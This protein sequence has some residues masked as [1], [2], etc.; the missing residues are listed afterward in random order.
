MTAFDIR[1]P[2]PTGTI[3][4]QASAGTGK[5]AAIAG[6]FAR[7]VAEGVASLPQ[8]MAATFSGAS[9]RELR[10]RIRDQLVS[11]ASA[12]S[13]RAAGGPDA[14]EV[15]DPVADLVSLVSEPELS[16]RLA[17]VEAALSGF[18]AATICTTHQFCDRMLAELGV[19]VDH[20]RSTVLVDDLTSMLEQ[21]VADEYLARFADSGDPPF[22]LRTARS[23]GK[24]AAVLSPALPLAPLDA[25]GVARERVAFAESVRRSV[26]ARKRLMGI[27][28]FDDM[29][30]RLRDALADD[31]DGLARAILRRRFPVV[32]IDEFQDTDPVQ[33]EIVDRAF[34][35]S[36][37]VVLIGDPKQ[38]IYGFRGADV[39]A[40]LAAVSRSQVQV[41]D[42]N[43]RSDPRL[44]RALGTLFAGA[45]LGDPRISVE[46][47][48]TGDGT[49]RLITDG[50]WRAPLRLRQGGPTPVSQKQADSAVDADLVTDVVALLRAKPN[51]ERPR[52]GACRPLAAADVAVI[53]SSNSRGEE[54]RRRLAE[55]GVP[56]V[57]NGSTSVLTS[58][59]ADDWRTLLAAFARPRS[60]EARRVARTDFIGWSLNDLATADDESLGRLVQLIRGWQRIAV[61]SGIGA[62]FEIMTAAGDIADRLLSR[63]GGDRVMTDLRHVAELLQAQQSREG[64]GMAQLHDWLDDQIRRRL[65]SR[66]ERSRR[67]ETD[68]DAVRIMTVHQSKGLQF[69]VVYFP[70]TTIPQPRG[71]RAHLEPFQVHQPVA[72]RLERFLDVGGERAPGAAARRRE[73]DREEAGEHLRR[74]YVALTRAECHLTV[75]WTPTKETPETPLH[76]ILFRDPSSREV[77]RSVPLDRRTPADLG[78]LVDSGISVEQLGGLEPAGIAGPTPDLTRAAVFSRAVDRTW[79]R[80]SYSA[81]TAHAHLDP[82]DEL[83]TADEPDDPDDAVPPE[84]GPDTPLVARPTS[85]NTPSPMADLPG[86]VAFGSL[87][88]AVFER[89]DP[90]EPGTLTA[91]VERETS[92]LP[93][94]NVTSQA[95]VETLRPA[96]ETPLGP[97][98][99]GCRLADIDSHDR[100]AEL[101]F[102]L[103]LGSGDWA[104]T[105]SDIARLLEA[106]LSADDPLA[107]YPRRLRAAG[108]S[109]DPLRGFLTGSIDA[110]IRVGERVVVVD[111]KTNRLC[112]PGV[113]LTLGHYTA[114][115][116]SEAMMASHY[117]LQALLYAVALHRFLRWRWRDY[118]AGT[119]LGGVAY[120]FVRGMAGAA[121]P[122]VGGMR[123]G[124]F[125]WQP[126]APL[127]EALSD[128]LAGLGGRE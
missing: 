123:T 42:T 12:L 10:S 119:H 16:T 37:T 5:T 33:W 25:E 35:G 115:A 69:P 52:Q 77:P 55:A 2:L 95:L 39:L 15:T 124:V 38:S 48:R 53:V 128:L 57:F 32:L 34:V 83:P 61:E 73:F 51:L 56:S 75:W 6:L 8:I 50:P 19:L 96:L 94:P 106:H 18:D 30:L 125:T 117:P 49:P 43:H 67:L 80:T 118:R 36:S 79:R 23:L 112:P 109:P 103:P 93:V 9:T 72:D 100:L 108:L 26:A 46:P 92:R 78:R 91:I 1:G 87:V 4:L 110:A 59:A 98:F 86:G 65:A 40:Y 82:A 102:E 63:K 70:E 60:R 28:T 84:A 97:L 54:V 76:R 113:E 62:M 31:R 89:F 121:T 85:L 14:V 22:D 64:L 104:A 41:L 47:V 24:F 13:A 107:G 21:T 114:D 126:P 101:D 99:D 105:L 66:D 74:L 45:D 90:R 17:R 11:C 88:H 81:L 111:Y 127:V 71:D 68:A 116:M 20:E 3:V 44:V 27:Y 29:Q 120:L 7:F 58:P 122:V